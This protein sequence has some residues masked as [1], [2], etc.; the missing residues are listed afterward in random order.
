MDAVEVT[1]VVYLPP[2]EVYECLVDFP[3]Y[4]RYSEHLKEVRQHGDGAPGTEY[5]LV[6]SWWKLSY[7]VRSRVTDVDP[8]GRIDWRVVEDVDAAG[9][10][11]VE[12]VPDEAPEGRETASRVTFRVEYRADSADPDLDLPPF[13]SLSWVVE[14]VQ[15][16]IE[17]EARRVVE[18]VVADFEGERREVDLRIR[19]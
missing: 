13:V 19:T 18:R 10:W 5:D 6:F 17:A 12:E 4:A 14:K 3:R 7:T 11:L 8:P 16:K 9:C 15:P 1:T 2:E